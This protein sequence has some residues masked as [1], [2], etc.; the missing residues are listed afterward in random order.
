M[1]HTILSPTPRV[2]SPPLNQM[3]LEKA[4]DHITFH[5]ELQEV[6]LEPTFL[7]V[8]EN[9]AYCQGKV[10]ECGDRGPRFPLF[11]DHF[12][13]LCSDVTTVLRSGLFGGN[14]W[15]DLFLTLS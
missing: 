3:K 9:R 6:T 7:V 4:R 12:G 10:I 11:R 5:C 15:S 8:N 1:T 14:E 13:H 2:R